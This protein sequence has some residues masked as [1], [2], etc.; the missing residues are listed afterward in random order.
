MNALHHFSSFTSS[1]ISSLEVIIISWV[2]W[3]ENTTWVFLHVENAWHHCVPNCYLPCMILNRCLSESVSDNFSPVFF[4]HPLTGPPRFPN[5]APCPPLFMRHLWQKRYLC[6]DEAWRSCSY[7][8]CLFLFC[9]NSWLFFEP[10][11]ESVHHVHHASRP[12]NKKKT[13][14]CFS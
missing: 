11:A 9:F 12:W 5:Y 2:I 3:N 8:Y 1:N 6:Y 10:F 13:L 14:Y 4:L 7:L